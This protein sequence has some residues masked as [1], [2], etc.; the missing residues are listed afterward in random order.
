MTDPR[1]PGRL[2]SNRTTQPAVAGRALRS[3]RCPGD[4][5]TSRTNSDGATPASATIRRG[6]TPGVETNDL[7]A[8]PRARTHARVAGMARVRHCHSAPRRRCT[9]PCGSSQRAS[10]R[11]GSPHTRSRIGR[12][13]ATPGERS[14]IVKPVRRIGRDE[15]EGRICLSKPDR[16]R[17][18][19]ASTRTGPWSCAASGRA[20]CTSGCMPPATTG[21][22]QQAVRRGAAVEAH[23][24]VH[25]LGREVAGHRRGHAAHRQQPRRHALVVGHVLRRVHAGGAR[26]QRHLRQGLLLRVHPA[27]RLPQSRVRLRPLQRHPPRR[28]PPVGQRLPHPQRGRHP[29][30]QR[31]RRERS[32]PDLPRRR[33][34]DHPVEPDSRGERGLGLPD[35]LGIRERHLA[36]QRPPDGQRRRPLR[37]EPRR[38]SV[39]QRRRQGQRLEPAARHHLGSERQGRMERDGK[40]GQVRGRDLQPGC[41]CVRRG[42]QSAD[43]DVSLSRAEHQRSGHDHARADSPGDSCRCSTG[44]ST[45][46]GPAPSR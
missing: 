12:R 40:R 42:R 2:S 31:R 5:A 38:R 17:S 44:S 10:S 8:R 22:H 1:S 9:S 16:R 28:Q 15:W 13:S 32:L 26:Q 30:R 23:P 29:L 6:S 25:R 21:D 35:S 37:Q 14:Q 34:H 11:R 24:R 41:R 4:P 43:A 33:H 7:D 18:T 45:T 19:T 20:V 39:R 27:I 46:A 3:A 36:P